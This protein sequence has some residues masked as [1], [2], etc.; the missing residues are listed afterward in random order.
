MEVS[1]SPHKDLI[2]CNCMSV[3]FNGSLALL[4]GRRCYAV[5]NLAT[6]D[7]LTYRET[8]QSK[9]EVIRAEWSPVSESVIAVAANNKVDL[10]TCAGAELSVE[11]SVSCFGAAWMVTASGVDT[12]R[13]MSQRN[14]PAPGS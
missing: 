9:W 1:V 2:G 12:T 8:R 7:T 14:I 13:R 3:N 10:L 11:R 6:P 4:A 5:I